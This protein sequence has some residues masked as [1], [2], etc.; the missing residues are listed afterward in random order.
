MP[1]TSVTVL[2]PEKQTELG[3]YPEAHFFFKLQT[4]KLLNAIECVSW[5]PMK[6]MED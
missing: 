6:T 4:Q 2:S 1:F 3:C 5:S